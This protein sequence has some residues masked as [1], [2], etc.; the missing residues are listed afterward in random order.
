MDFDVELKVL[1]VGNT[2]VGKTNLLHRFSGGTFSPHY[3]ATIGVDCIVRYL[4][5][6]H[7]VYKINCWDTAGQERFRAM[8]R[9]IYRGAHLG[10]F[11]YDVSSSQSYLDLASWFEDVGPN[12]PRYI[13]GNKTDLTPSI[14]DQDVE[15]DYPNVPH[16]QCS[17]LVPGSVEYTLSCLLEH[18]VAHHDLPLPPT[19]PERI[20]RECC[21][22]A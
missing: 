8:T 19:P 21:I 22:L 16:F 2:G 15:R 3:I 14:G 11:V 7:Q 12:I 5:L 6:H 9:A 20:K 1:I 18:F 4:T 10:I 17:C 13:V